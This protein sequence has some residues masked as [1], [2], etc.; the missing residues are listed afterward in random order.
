MAV[1]RPLFLIL[2]LALRHGAAMSAPPSRA[3][4]TGVRPGVA[5]ARAPH[6]RATAHP[7]PPTVNSRVRHLAKRRRWD[8]AL[9]EA[10]RGL[11]GGQLGYRSAR[12]ALFCACRARQP[13]ACEAFFRDVVAARPPAG[14]GKWETTEHL[15]SFALDAH[16]RDGATARACDLLEDAQR[17]GI[18]PTALSYCILIKGFGR[19]GERTRDPAVVAKCVARIRDLMSLVEYRRAYDRILL[20]AAVDALARCGDA[21]RATR[22][23]GRME[24]DFGVS[25]GARAYN[26]A[27]KSLCHE[28]PRECLALAR[29]MRRAGVAAT[30]VTN[31]TLAHAL[32]H[33]K[34]ETAAR[35]LPALFPHPVA[36]PFFPAGDAAAAVDEGAVEY[37]Q[38]A[39][40]A[41]TAVLGEFANRGDRV[42]AAKVFRSMRDRQVPRSAVTYA[43]LLRVSGDT[44]EGVA[45][46]WSS[47]EFD[48]VAPTAVTYNV[49]VA[50]LLGKPADGGPGEARLRKALA[51]ARDMRG[52]VGWTTA[53]LNTI[54][55]ALYAT[56]GDEAA[57]TWDAPSA[58]GRDGS[59]RA[60]AL[61][62]GCGVAGTWLPAPDAATWTIAMRARARR[63]D[64]DGAAD[65]WRR[66]RRDPT[67][68]VDAIAAN[69]Y[70]DALA[71][72]GALGDARD[73]L[74][75][76]RKGETPGLPRP[77]AVS[78][79]V[80]ARALSA[81]QHPAAARACL[82]V[83]DWALDDALMAP[84]IAKA[85]I[86]ACTSLNDN[87]ASPFDFGLR[88][89]PDVAAAKRV[90]DALDGTLPPASVTKLRLF[91]HQTLTRFDTETWKGTAYD[92]R[93]LPAAFR[94]PSATDKIFRNKGW[95]EVE[96]GFKLI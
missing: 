72:G 32:G 70:V 30:A 6:H 60:E 81:A 4:K 54:L 28:A 36:C 12:D 43:E 58:D 68:A 42:G 15:L 92:D 53:T 14:G 73:L 41:Y 49:A 82:D 88:A 17:A 25:P 86:L 94:K 1:P 89:R 33:Y 76:M 40:V 2:T 39:T 90:L 8:D 29:R 85:T 71:R 57:P 23:L 7:P 34:P 44:E 96:S 38:S 27:L 65:A 78:Y 84:A 13:A 67:L 77:D 46:I 63:G 18:A 47:M 19:E 91:A 20:N 59:A 69:T 62:D 75:A 37:R 35:L 93:R 79:A 55:A 50:A 45:R 22:L 31:A 16:A 66:L 51:L 10:R 48:G 11:E 26:A 52:S 21:A 56:A 64:L 61:L 3:V 83:F 95:N 74:E 87:A 9:A 80:V 24:R 5:P